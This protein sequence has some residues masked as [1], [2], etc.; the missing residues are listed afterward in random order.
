MAARRNQ[1][2]KRYTRESRSD[3]YRA[4]YLGLGPERSL[5]KLHTFCAENMPGQKLHL[6]T[7]KGYSVDYHWVEAA[8]EFDQRHGEGSRYTDQ[9]W[10]ALLEMDNRHMQ[11]GRAL[12]SKGAEALAAIN[13]RDVSAM[14][15]AAMMREGVR[16]ERV[17]AG[18]VTDRVEVTI[19]SL[20]AAVMAA[21]IEFR[22]SLNRLFPEA[23][24]G[25]IELAFANFSQGLDDRMYRFMAEKNINLSELSE[26]VIEGELA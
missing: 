26:M 17:A 9:A 7:L 13:T 2:T 22:S 14:G 15:I 25:D 10:A 20:N 3:F 8:L 16:I 12:Q 6:N 23:T 24:E 19:D 1:H 18:V 11:I 21:Q 4:I 5:L